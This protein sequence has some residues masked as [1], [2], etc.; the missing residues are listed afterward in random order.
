MGI[1]FNPFSG[2]LDFTGGATATTWNSPVATEGDLP[3]PG[4]DGEARV[5]LATD[6]VY[7]WDDGS[8]K[9]IIT[10]IEASAF[11]GTSAEGI[12]IGTN[13]TGD[14][15]ARTIQLNEASAT[16]PG[17][18]SIGTQSF[19]GNKTFTGTITASNLSGTNTGD[20]SVT[21]V[22]SSPNAN[23]A[24]INTSGAVQAFGTLTASG[25]PSDGDTF[26]VTIGVHTE[27]LTYKTT[28]I[29]PNDILISINAVADSISR[30]NVVFTSLELVAS[31]DS[32]V[33]IRVTAGSSYVGTAGNGSLRIQKSSSVL[34]VGNTDGSGYA[35]NGSNSITQQ[36]Q[37][38]PADSTNP[39]VVT[40][41]TQTFGGAKTFAS[42]VTVT[43]VTY[44]NGGV[45]VTAT[46]G[47]DT[48]SIGT[49]GADII[50][51]G[52]SGTIVNINTTNLNV[53]D[54]LTTINVGGSA[55]SASNSGVQIEENAI[56]T[57]YAETSADRD[58]W[59][60]KAPNQTGIAT[61]SPG[62]SGIT[63]DQSSHNPLTLTTVGATPNANGASLSTQALT[64]QPANAS[65][66]G[67]LTAAD[68]STFNGKANSTLNN[69]GS[70]AVNAS[71]TPASNDTVSLGTTSSHWLQTFSTS[72]FSGTVGS[73]AKSTSGASDSVTLRTGNKTGGGGTLASGVLTVTT[74]TVTGTTG[75]IGNI[76][77]STA[78]TN[79][80]QAPGNVSLYTGTHTGTGDAPSGNVSIYTG[81]ANNAGASGDMTIGTGAVVDGA[82]G[83]IILAPGVTSGTGT[84]GIVS[85]VGAAT[86]SKD[87]TINGITA[88]RGDGNDPANTAF[89]AGALANNSSG[90]VNTAVGSGALTSSGAGGNANTATGYRA[91]NLLTSGNYNTAFGHSAAAFLSSGDRNTSIGSLSG[92]VSGSD[93]FA[94]GQTS[95]QNNTGSN[96]VGVGNGT[97]VNNTTG[98]SNTA[99]GTQSLST[100]ITGSAN[101]GVGHQA[102]STTEA[103]YNTSVGHQSLIDNSSG[104]N[105]VAVGSAAGTASTSNTTGSYNT[106]LGSD[107]GNSGSGTLTKA[108]AIGYGA[109]VGAS[110]AMVLG[111]SGANAVNVGVEITAPTARLNLPGGT[112]TAGTSSLKIESGTLL[113]TPEDGAI[114]SD[115]NSL[116]FTGTGGIRKNLTPNT[117]DISQTSFTAA[118]NQATPADVT[119]FAFANASVQA[120]SADV[121]VVRSST[122]AKFKIEGIQKAASWDISQPYVGDNTGIVFSITSS[123]QVQYTST[124]TG[125]TASIKFRATT[126]ST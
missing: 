64:L 20:V 47:T 75:T 76:Q 123:G 12:Q 15:T 25:L 112:A 28:P 108:V 56:I 106:Y 49:S 18:V 113:T 119:G 88:G 17:G 57:A 120:F 109:L 35:Q 59:I 86:V 42:S 111:G 74:G 19:A 83:N 50:N 11:A 32:P 80:T 85:V 46:G 48:L 8:A 14:I 121:S 71:I 51:I 84:D 61:V 5:V 60:F 30:L 33:V 43:G 89:G 68:W 16:T 45:D 37:L 58:S 118:D 114:E 122:Y 77:I 9:W 41:S 70:T 53:V 107:T 92:P 91:L 10:S 72:T 101:V 115:G 94:C 34:T 69:L 6:K 126:L 13:T 90:T 54:K 73:P 99:I 3:V 87:M 1:T 65:F 4:T 44:A 78:D 105:N 21:T 125:S 97:L 39:G 96:N 26:T 38:E 117:G 27:I 36:L 104:T 23:G 124:N 31:Q 55:G 100:N 95:L 52:N 7:V 63:L 62:A 40:A 22:G 29:N 2:T 116:Y 81:D 93:N 110:N 79:G 82:A 103:N 66:P 24:V 67:V 102:L 98:S